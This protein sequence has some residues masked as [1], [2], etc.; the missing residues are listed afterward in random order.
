MTLDTC[1][2]LRDVLR[3]VAPHKD[4]PADDDDLFATGVLDSFATVELIAVL[5]QTFRVTL[6]N[7]ELTLQ[8]FQT[9]SSIGALVD[10]LRT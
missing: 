7:E 8:N 9:I 10:R 2:R 1:A 5:E 6:P 4:L 3:T